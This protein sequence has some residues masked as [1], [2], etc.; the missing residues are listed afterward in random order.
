GNN[1]YT[2]NNTTATASN[3]IED[4]DAGNT[5]NATFNVQAN[6]VQGGASNT[7]SGFGGNDRFEVNFAANTS[8]PSAAGTTFQ[9][10][11]GTA[12]TRDRVDLNLNA[13]G[14]V[15]ARTVGFTYASATSGDVDV[16]GLGL[17]SGTPLD[18]NT[19]EQVNYRGDAS[20]ND[21]L[22]VTG[23]SGDDTLSV[24]P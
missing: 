19:V 3:L 22:S 16:T 18:L 8:I 17:P 2:I 1:V 6:A 20:N 10:N 9:V 5:G 11:G 7:F 21:T 12:T 14:D 23:T 4:G 15:T 13:G 24:T